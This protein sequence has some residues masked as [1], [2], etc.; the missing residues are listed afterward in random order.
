MLYV[1]HDGTHGRGGGTMTPRIVTPVVISFPEPKDA[2][3]MNRGEHEVLSRRVE[4]PN[5]RYLVSSDLA[6]RPQRDATIP[7]PDDPQS[8]RGS[9]GC[10]VC[11]YDPR[12][13]PLHANCSIIAD[14]VIPPSWRRL[15][16]VCRKPTRRRETG[17]EED[18]DGL[19]SRPSLITSYI[20]S[21]GVESNGLGVVR[22]SH[23]C[24][25]VGYEERK[26]AG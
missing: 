18:E 5:V 7:F 4:I 8:D 24:A 11:F 3:V 12:F 13:V 22:Q 17:I 23:C 6:T 15:V 26:K 19:D 25:R 21:D 10:V 9:G 2:I 20:G 16:P 14:P 1:G